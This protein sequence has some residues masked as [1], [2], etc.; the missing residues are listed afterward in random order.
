MTTTTNPQWLERLKAVGISRAEQRRIDTEFINHLLD[1]GYNKS[2]IA[3]ICD[4]SITWVTTRM[5]G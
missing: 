5:K 1:Q 4:K 2:E 3:R